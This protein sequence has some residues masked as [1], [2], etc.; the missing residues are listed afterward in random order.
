[1]AM[2][3]QIAISVAASFPIS[4]GSWCSGGGGTLLGFLGFN[5]REGNGFGDDVGEELEVILAGDCAC[6]EGMLG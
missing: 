1:M 6:C 4:I 5:D 2:R 3:M